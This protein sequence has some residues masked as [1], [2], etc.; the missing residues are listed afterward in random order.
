MVFFMTNNKRQETKKLIESAIAQN[1]DT[2]YNKDY[3]CYVKKGQDPQEALAK[4]QHH[5]SFKND[6]GE[7]APMGRR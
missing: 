3:G 1:G 5:R 7:H 2:F 4:A 6:G